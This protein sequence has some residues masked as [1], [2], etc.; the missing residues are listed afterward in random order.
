VASALGLYSTIDL[1][2]SLII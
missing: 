1:N 2:V